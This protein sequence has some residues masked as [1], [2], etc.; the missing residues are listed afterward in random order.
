MLLDE[1][2]GIDSSRRELRKFGFVMAGALAV[3]GGLLLWRG[4]PYYPYFFGCS[5]VFTALGALLPTVLLPI[6]KAWMTLAV[7]LGWIMTR[8]I[9][10]VLFY[11]VLTPMGLL[12][13]LFGK[14]ILNM[15]MERDSASSYWIPRQTD[16]SEERDYQR[17]F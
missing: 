4:K 3:I 6:Q 2:R 15:K 16:E 14:D 13:R 5:V 12:M 17:Q 1:I 8:V 10:C 7:I 11:L 9:L